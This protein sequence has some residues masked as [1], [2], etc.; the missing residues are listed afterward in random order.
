MNLYIQQQTT[1][2][3]ILDNYVALWRHIFG[4][5]KLIVI[6]PRG[7]YKKRNQIKKHKI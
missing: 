7:K 6:K 2:D 5:K 4:D 1:E 3:Q